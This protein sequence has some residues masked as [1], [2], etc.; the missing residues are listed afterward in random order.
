MVRKNGMIKTY[1]CGKNRYMLRVLLV[2]LVLFIGGCDEQECRNSVDPVFVDLEVQRIDQQLFQSKSS[3]EIASLLTD[4]ENFA[5]LFLDADEY[6]SNQILADRIYQLIQNPAIDTLYQ[7]SVAAF[8]DIDVIVDQIGDALGRLKVY[9]PSTPSPVIQTA[10]TGLYKDLVITNE[11]V[12]IGMDFFIGENA[13]YPP[14]QIPDYILKR[15]DTDHL[16]ANIMQFISSQYIQQASGETM[17]AEMIDHGKSYYLLS[18]LLPCTPEHILMGYTTEE[19]KD[20]FENDGIIWA[21]FIENELLYETNHQM[22][23]K[24]L[25]ER[26]NVYEIGEKCPGRIGRWLGWQIVKSYARETGVGIQEL[27]AEKDANKVLRLSEYK[28]GQS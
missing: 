23:Q 26:P 27:M 2:L 15:Y 20:S 11:Q 25:G 10:V 3:A 9:Y 19:W 5:K 14:Q 17:L 8:S 7:E 13:S 22:K 1:F 12:I 18:Q 6:P 28:P 16:P 24:F 4:H 21:N